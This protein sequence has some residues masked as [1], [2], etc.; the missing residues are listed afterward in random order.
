MQAQ[1]LELWKELYSMTHS[2]G[3]KTQNLRELNQSC[4]TLL[5]VNHTSDKVHGLPLHS[6][7]SYPLLLLIWKILKKSDLSLSEKKH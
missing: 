6:L 4:T 5:S 7:Q 1:Q 3:G 2:K